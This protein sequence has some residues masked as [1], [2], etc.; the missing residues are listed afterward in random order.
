MDVIRKQRTLSA[1]AVVEGVGYWSGE[2]VRVEFRPADPHE[3]IT[4]VRA[5]LPGAPRIAAA[6]ENLVEMPRRTVLQNGSTCVEMIEH[7]MAALAGMNVDNCEVRVDRTE[8]PGCDG[9]AMPFVEAIQLAGAEEQNAVRPSLTIREPL[10]LGNEECW[11]EARPSSPG[12]TVIQY[13]L[14]YGSGNPIGRQSLEV[15]LSPRYFARSLAASRTFLLQH[16]AAALQAQGL[17]KRTTFS[18]LLI[19]DS[20][21]ARG[22]RIR[23]LSGRVRAS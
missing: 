1:A 18:D 8:M 15:L 4:F 12:K 7:I 10:R 13:E 22:Q 23:A 9:S 2:D 17:G 6:V 14:D 3:G 16:E 20:K 21:W 11:I 19:F 5:D